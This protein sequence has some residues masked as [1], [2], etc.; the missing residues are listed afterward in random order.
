METRSKRQ[1][2]MQRPPYPQLSTS[3]SIAPSQSSASSAFQSSSSLESIQSPTQGPFGQHLQSPFNQSAPLPSPL[4]QQPATYFGSMSVAAAPPQA[5]RNPSSNQIPGYAGQRG[6][7]GQ[8]P[9]TAPFLDNFNLVA[10]A[11]K[12]A[13]MACLMR[14]LGDVEL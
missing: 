8:A 9:V 11:A 6:D 2:A 4:T 5:Q 13:Q 7:N 12:R 10:E 14:D 1:Q 3:T